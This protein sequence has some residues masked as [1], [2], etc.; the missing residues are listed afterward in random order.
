MCTR[1]SW[2]EL[3]MKIAA[4]LGE[5]TSCVQLQVGCVFVDEL[6]RIVTVG[7]NGPP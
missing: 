6:H 4:T 1:L 5:R 7:Y 2:D 3:F